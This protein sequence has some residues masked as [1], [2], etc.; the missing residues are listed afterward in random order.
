MKVY[1]KYK[2]CNRC[3]RVY[4]DNKNKRVLIKKSRG[5]KLTVE[6]LKIHYRTMSILKNTVKIVKQNEKHIKEV[7][8][9]FF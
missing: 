7:E 4:L 5:H 8:R 1:K 2:I 9:L 3:H 6:E